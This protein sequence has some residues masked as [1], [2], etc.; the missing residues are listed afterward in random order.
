C[1]RHRGAGLRRAGLA[2][3]PDRGGG[4]QAREPGT[5]RAAAAHGSTRRNAM[6]L[7]PEVEHALLTAIRAPEPARSRRRRGQRVLGPAVT[8]ALACLAVAVAVGALLLLS[9]RH[10]AQA[11][12]HGPSGAGQVPSTRQTLLATLGVLR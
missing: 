1:P 4:P 12:A 2:R 3:A 7:L 8:V 9:G 5:G 10:A 11:P 6:T